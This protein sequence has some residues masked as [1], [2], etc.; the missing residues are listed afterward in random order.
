MPPLLPRHDSRRAPVRP[1][2]DAD[3][4]EAIARRTLDR[5]PAPFADSLGDIVLLIEDVAD[6]ETARS[7]GFATRCN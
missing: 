3:E 1:N 5:L 7:V 6:A 4:I 2:A